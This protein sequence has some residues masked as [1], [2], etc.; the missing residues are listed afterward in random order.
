MA[1]ALD[2]L[3]AM[4]WWAPKGVA[5]EH[6]LQGYTSWLIGP[7]AFSEGFGAALIGALIYAHLM[8]CLMAIYYV[9]ARRFALLWEH[10]LLCGGVYGALAYFAIFQMIVPMLTGASA[11][12][13]GISWIATC[14][15][16]YMTFVGM[17]CAL[18]SRAADRANR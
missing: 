1:A 12:A 14:V 18:F 15:V 6:I 2:T 9:C 11:T 4:G 3:V 13:H 7:A 5:P 17:P 8:S 10:P 16:T